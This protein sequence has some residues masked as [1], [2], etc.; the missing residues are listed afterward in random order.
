M[1]DCKKLIHDIDNFNIHDHSLQRA[2]SASSEDIFEMQDRIFESVLN[3]KDRLLHD[4][5]EMASSKFGENTDDQ[6]FLMNKA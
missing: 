4:I 3:E 6:K 1:I 2:P 5:K